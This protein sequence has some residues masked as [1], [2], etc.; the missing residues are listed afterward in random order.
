MKK[1]SKKKKLN[2]NFDRQYRKKFLKKK[3]AR[4]K[5]NVFRTHEGSMLENKKGKDKV[6]AKS[7]V[8]DLKVAW[9]DTSPFSNKEMDHWVGIAFIAIDDEVSD[10][11]CSTSKAIQDQVKGELH[12]MIQA[13]Q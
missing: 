7:K 10:T 4:E 12:L 8:R 9:D 13:R 5:K 3:R 1:P 11:V 2:C 6:K